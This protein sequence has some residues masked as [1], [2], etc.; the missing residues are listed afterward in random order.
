ML[1]APV[2][3]S[4]STLGEGPLRSGDLRFN[5]PVRA[6]AAKDMLHG[7]WAAPIAWLVAGA[8]RGGVRGGATGVVAITRISGRVAVP[9]LAAG[10]GFSCA[11]ATLDPMSQAIGAAHSP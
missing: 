8:A 4:N 3:I 9:A 7:L 5:R 2:L 11:A 10:V 6:T 1:C